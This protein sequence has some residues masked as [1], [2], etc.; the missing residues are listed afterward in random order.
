[1]KRWIHASD[2]STTKKEKESL[3]YRYIQN[4]LHS[5]VTDVE[6]AIKTNLFGDPDNEII[7]DRYTD[8]YINLTLDN[9]LY[10]GDDID[11][12]MRR[13]KQ[14]YTTLDGLGAYCWIVPKDD[15]MQFHV[16]VFGP[17]GSNFGLEWL[18]DLQSGGDGSICCNYF[19][20]IPSRMKKKI[21]EYKEKILGYIESAGL[22]VLGLAKND[23]DGF[24]YPVIDDNYKELL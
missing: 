15:F 9:N 14:I 11:D 13:T 20:R 21:D 1:M 8:D 2:Y 16:S 6:D 18:A 7:F 3:R 19:S 10:Y 12:W 17:R 22:E 4:Q 5:V 23:S 24:W